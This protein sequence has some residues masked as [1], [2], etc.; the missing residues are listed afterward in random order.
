MITIDVIFGKADCRAFGENEP[1]ESTPKEFHT[2]VE[3]KAYI[4]GLNDANGYSECGVIIPQEL[5]DM[6]PS[7]T[8]DMWVVQLKI[9]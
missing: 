1:Y 8:S 7:H 3:A 4:R 5:S 2:Q 9:S 6:D